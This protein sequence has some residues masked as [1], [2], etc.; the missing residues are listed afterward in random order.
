[1]TDVVQ[2]HVLT[3]GVFPGEKPAREGSL[4]TATRCELGVSC[5]TLSQLHFRVGGVAISGYE[6]LKALAGVRSHEHRE[7]LPIVDNSQNMPELEQAMMDALR[8]HAGAHGILIRGH[9]LYTWGGDLEEANRHLEAILV[10]ATGP[11]TGRSR[12]R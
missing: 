6:M 4:M 7:W 11:G 12:I 5:T 9:G 1:V 10:C 2:A 8:R 3:D